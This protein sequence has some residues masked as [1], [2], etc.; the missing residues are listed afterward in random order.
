MQ[1]GKK[2]LDLARDLEATDLIVLLEKK[3][4]AVRSERAK[5]AEKKEFN[6]PKVRR[7]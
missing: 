5:A 2:P 6:K 4:L 3:M 7:I 1:D